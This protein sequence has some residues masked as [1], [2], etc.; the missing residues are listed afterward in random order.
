MPS[1]IGNRTTG[2]T[3]TVNDNIEVQLCPNCTFP[4]YSNARDCADCGYPLQDDNIQWLRASS[5]KKCNNP[6]C[7][8]YLCDRDRRCRRCGQS[9]DE[10]VVHSVSP[11]TDPETENTYVLVCPECKKNNP[12]NAVS[13][14]ACGCSLEDVDPSCAS[15]DDPSS[16]QDESVTVHIEN[17]RTRKKVSLRVNPGKA[18]TIGRDA[19]LSEQLVSTVYVSYEHVMLSY[20]EETLWITDTSSNGTYIDGARLD[21]NMEIPLFSGTLIGLGDPSASELK[22][23]FFKITY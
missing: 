9:T 23:A 4:N 6:N 2:V 10:S 1:F 8:L 17:I 13:C 19:Q 12:A 5:V 21:K 16:I 15:V 14:S 11:Q 7:G 18:V 20:H 22:A 3:T